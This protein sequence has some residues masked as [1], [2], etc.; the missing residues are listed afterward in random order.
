MQAGAG[1]GGWGSGYLSSGKDG[2][3][4][5]VLLKATLGFRGASGLRESGLLG[6]EARATGSLVHV[7][8]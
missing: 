7:G 1:V 3:G 8:T 4:L 5:S 6:T 2:Q